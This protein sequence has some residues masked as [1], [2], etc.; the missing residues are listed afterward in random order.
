MVMSENNINKNDFYCFRIH[1]YLLQY[2]NYKNTYVEDN[3]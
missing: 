1:V 3:T 2:M